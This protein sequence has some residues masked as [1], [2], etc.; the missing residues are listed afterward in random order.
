M[1]EAKPGDKDLRISHT[2]GK[3]TSPRQWFT[4]KGKVATKGKRAI[5]LDGYRKIRKTETVS[6]GRIY[7]STRDRSATTQVL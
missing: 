6:Q 3:A 2:E 7:P 1:G 5:G 4:A